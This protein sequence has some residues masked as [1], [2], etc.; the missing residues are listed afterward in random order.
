MQ[1]RVAVAGAKIEVFPRQDRPPPVIG[2]G[3]FDGLIVDALQNPVV[4]AAFNRFPEIDD[5]KVAFAQQSLEGFKLPLFL[6]RPD[7]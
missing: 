1:N 6:C 3:N 7:S 2:I 4:A 5:H